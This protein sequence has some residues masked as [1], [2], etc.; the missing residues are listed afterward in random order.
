MKDYYN[1]AAGKLVMSSGTDYN[2]QSQQ[3]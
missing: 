1:R 2:K 3:L